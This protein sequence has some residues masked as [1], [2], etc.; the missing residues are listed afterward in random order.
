MTPYEVLYERK[1]KTPLCWYHDG[2]I[3]LVGS[4]L[5]QQTTEKVKK[6]QD[7]MKASQSRQKSY[8]NERR[9]SGK[10]DE[11]VYVKHGA[12]ADEVF[13]VFDVEETEDDL[14]QDMRL[15]WEESTRLLG[16]MVLEE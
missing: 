4:E 11:T 13:V 15:W 3:I 1:C 8:A 7:K 6:I 12:C 14:D 5:I 2:E 10:G 9:S 16:P